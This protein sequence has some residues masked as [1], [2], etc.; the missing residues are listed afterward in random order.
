[1]PFEP[2]CMNPRRKG[3][4]RKTGLCEPVIT[5][6]AID[7]MTRGQFVKLPADCYRVNNSEPVT[8]MA[9]I[10]QIQSRSILKC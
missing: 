5:T 10:R 9:D 3:G 7:G 1:M 4:N 6:R 8:N 2:C